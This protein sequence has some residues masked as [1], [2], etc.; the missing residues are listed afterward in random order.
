M[1][2]RSVA[3]GDRGEAR[4]E[5]VPIRAAATNETHYGLMRDQKPDD[6]LSL[7]TASLRSSA[8][9]SERGGYV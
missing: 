2:D 3:N 8:S 7:D 5:T 9:V 4:A 1:G 6:T